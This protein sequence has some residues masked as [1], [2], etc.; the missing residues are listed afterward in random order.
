MAAG[1]LSGA[2]LASI[3]WPHLT[4]TSWTFLRRSPNRNHRAGRVG[5]SL[6]RSRTLPLNPVCRVPTT[7]PRNLQSRL[8]KVHNMSKSALITGIT[9]QDGSYL[10]ELLLEGL[11]GPRADPPLLDLQHR[12]HRPPLPGPARA[13]RAPV[14]ALRRPDRRL[15]LVTLLREHPARRGLQPGRAVPCPGLVRRARVHRRHHRARHASGCWRPIRG[16]GVK[17]RFYQASTSEMFGCARRRRRTR[18]RRSIRAPVRGGQGVRLLDDGQLP[19]G[20][21]PVRRQRHPVQPRVPAARRDLRH[22]QDHPGGGAHR[23]GHAGH[24]YLGNLDAAATG[25]TP[26]STS[27][28]CGGCCRPT[29]PPTTSWRPAPWATVQQFLGLLR[30]GRAGPESA[31][32]MFDP[33]TFDPPKSTV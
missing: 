15:A 23:G 25:V 28:P 31:H 24:L 5:V 29:R 32:V 27:R 9:G 13:G 18:R 30:R 19:R 33:P 22:P 11:R 3:R 8:R 7:V 14:P 4:V 26:R 1:R 17:T 21:R 16:C 2:R 12:P 10:A 20:L 6:V